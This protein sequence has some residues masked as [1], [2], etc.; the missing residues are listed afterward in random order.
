MSGQPCGAPKMWC[1]VLW[2][3][4]SPDMAKCINDACVLIGTQNLFMDKADFDDEECEYKNMSERGIVDENDDGLL[5]FTWCCLTDDEENDE[6]EYE[7]SENGYHDPYED[8]MEG[9]TGWLMCLLFLTPN[10]WW[11]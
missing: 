8:D 1:S 11:L 5:I 10:V 7:V 9:K 3:S 4:P 2:D 6:G